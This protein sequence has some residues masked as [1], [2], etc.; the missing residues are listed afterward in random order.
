M[1]T[2]YSQAESNVRRTWFLITMFF[3]IV[4]LIGWLFSYVFDS[5]IILYI[6]V[7]ISIIMS[8]SSYW[9]S[10]KII[11]SIT[12][13]KLVKMKDNP[14]IYR[15]V[16]N[17]CIATGMPL[18]QIYILEDE[19]Q[20]N[21][22]ATGRDEKHAVIALTKGIIE[23]LDRSELEGVIAHELA[24]IKNKDTLLQAVIVVLVGVI[25]VMSDIFLRAGFR[26]NDNERGGNVVFLML[27]VLVAILA[28]IAAQIIKA[29]LSRQREFLADASGA[30][31]TRYPEGLASAL[32]KIS[33][34]QNPLIKANASNAH[35]FISSPFRQKNGH[36]DWFTKLFM[37]H[38]PVEERIQALT[39]MKLS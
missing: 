22:F 36:V 7:L 23:K 15:L 39:G 1:A 19:L 26:R 38:P 10:D 3:V 21:A 35:L 29:S 14:E 11:L 17:L 18:P 16:E 13:A 25:V 6:A 2:L 31:I 12:N 30:L 5:T 27:G 4:I 28:P 24:H 33:A 34:D 20:P 8:I 32:R 9:F 37:T